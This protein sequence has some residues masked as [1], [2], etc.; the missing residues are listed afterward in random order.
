MNDLELVVLPAR[1]ERIIIW[2]ERHLGT[3]P[4]EV[5]D[6]HWIAE[7]FVDIAINDART[8]LDMNIE[9]MSEFWYTVAMLNPMALLLQLH[10]SP[11]L[12]DQDPEL[13]YPVLDRFVHWLP[14][15]LSL[16]DHYRDADE[17]AYSSFNV[18]RWADSIIQCVRG[19]GCNMTRADVQNEYDG[20]VVSA[21][22]DKGVIAREDGRFRRL[23]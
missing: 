8:G 21:L 5:W 1:P 15:L 7:D 12:D 4:D 14:E 20:D 11:S 10:C 22:L 9:A 18:A 2:H 3:E 13:Y 19:V 6:L 17:A 23:W 16:E